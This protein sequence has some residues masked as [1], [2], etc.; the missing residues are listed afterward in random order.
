MIEVKSILYFFDVIKVRWVIR[1]R[2]GKIC[3]SRLYFFVWA[4]RDDSLER[5]FRDTITAV[6]YSDY[7]F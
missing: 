3:L 6:H 1:M 4:A 2:A 7:L 5:Y